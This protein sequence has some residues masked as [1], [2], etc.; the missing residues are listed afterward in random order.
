MKRVPSSTATQSRTT[1]TPFP[2]TEEQVCDC[3]TGGAPR[4]VF[5]IVVL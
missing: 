4:G 5:S 3:G 1:V 2:R